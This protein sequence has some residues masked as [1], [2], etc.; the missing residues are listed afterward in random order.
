MRHYRLRTLAYMAIVLLGL[1]TALPTILP[2]ALLQGAP[3]WYAQQQLTLGLD[4]RGGSHLLFRVETGELVS[5]EMQQVAATVSQ[6][7][8]KAGIAHAP[9]RPS[10]EGVLIGLRSPAA[11]ERGYELARQLQSAD[12]VRRFEIQRLARGLALTPTPDLIRTLTADAVTRSLD[13]L[14]QRLNESGVV[15]PLITQQGTDGVLVQLPGVDDPSRIKALLGRTARLTFHLEAPAMAAGTPDTLRLSGT[16][17][18]SR[19]LVERRPLL[20]GDNL[21][22]ATLGFDPATGEAVVNFRLDPE[23]ADLF[24]DITRTSVGRAFAVVLDRQVITAPVIRTPITGGAGQISGSFTVAQATDLALV[25]RTGALP[26]ALS[27]VEERSVGPDLGQEAIAMGV[28][29]GILGALLVLA[30]MVVAYGTWGLIAN[31]AL[32]IYSVLVVA[33]LVALGATLTLPGI[34]GLILSLGMAVDA[35]I[36]INERI[37]EEARRGVSAPYAVQQGF[38]RAFATILDSNIT[39]LIAVG[40]L[41][42]FGSG[43]V[44]GFAVTMAVGLV[45]SMFTSIAVT[46]LLMEWRVRR[47]GRRPLVLGGMLRRSAGAGG[48]GIAFLRMRWAGLGLSAVLS[49]AAIG[50][51]FSPGL[52]TG[53]DFRGGTLVEVHSPGTGGDQLRRTLADAGLEDA[54]I[55]AIGVGGDY[56][57]RLPPQTEIATSGDTVREVKTAILAAIPEASFPRAEMVGPSVSSQFFDTSVLAV[58]LAGAG[59]FAYLSLRFE[60]HFATAAM[61]T[62]ALDLTKTLGF[63]AIT[64]IEF[65][66]TAIAA[67]LALIGYSVNDKVVV[68][69]RIRETLRAHPEQPLTDLINDSLNATLARTVFTSATTFL[70]ILPMGIAGGD[71]VASFALPMLFGIVIGTSS[72]I[73]IA[74]PLVLFLRQRAQ[75]REALASMQNPGVAPELSMFMREDRP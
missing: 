55:Q 16:D 6:Q 35:N 23:G 43:P 14:R 20:E 33:I 2:A 31:A 34:A 36:L 26:A 8:R 11:M 28:T 45:V 42:L 3:S 71:A 60:R 15:E 41:F 12:S 65:N 58:L 22:D 37:R 5:E 72:S 52:A 67:L 29:T 9:P 19:Y 39:T 1:V 21:T 63:L 74:A 62:L 46:R 51:L 50:L 49:M 69:D 24:A 75:A 66:L 38:R 32:L 44:R 73:Y 59:M 57:I 7:L 48:G 68:F 25:L 40:L 61:V 4:L 17:P 18:G 64:G 70:A 54:G 47:L 27:V 13:V 56:R 10:A 30:F 53:I